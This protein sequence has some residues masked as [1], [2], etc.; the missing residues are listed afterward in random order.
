MKC[1][2]CGSE[3]TTG[4]APNSAQCRRCEQTSISS[5]LNREQFIA[6]HIRALAVARYGKAGLSRTH[7]PDCAIALNGRHDC[8]C[9]AK[10][11]KGVME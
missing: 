10:N 5:C 4:D 7:A 2:K 6:R 8:S 9:G 1:W 3:L 11:T